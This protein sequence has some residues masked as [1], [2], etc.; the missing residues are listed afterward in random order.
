MISSPPCLFTA[1]NLLSGTGTPRCLILER[2]TLSPGV[3]FTDGAT[4]TTVA[5]DLPIP[6]FI[7][8]G[9]VF[10][11]GFADNLLDDYYD[12]TISIMDYVKVVR[13]L[14]RLNAVDIN[15]L[16]FL[17]PVYIEYFNS[18]FYINKISGYQPDG[19]E[20]TE[21]ELVKLF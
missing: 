8:D 7:K 15:Q 21:V 6:Y 4:T 16:D 14:I 10:N 17:K 3:D 2:Q 1:S 11:Y 19:N 18:Y 13:P 5:A 9:A 20:S 12:L